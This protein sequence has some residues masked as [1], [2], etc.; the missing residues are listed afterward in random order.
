MPVSQNAADIRGGRI[1]PLTIRA[2]I[3]I[4]GLAFVDF[5]TRSEIVE[6]GQRFKCSGHPGFGSSAHELEGGLKA[7]STPIGFGPL[8]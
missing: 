1:T 6:L 7:T 3:P 5:G 4:E 2:A 8:I